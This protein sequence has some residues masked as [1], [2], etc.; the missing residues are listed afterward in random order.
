MILHPVAAWTPTDLSGP[1]RVRVARELG[2]AALRS[3]AL[4]AGYSEDA[5]P[6]RFPRDTAGAP[7]PLDPLRDPLGGEGEPWHWS[8]TGS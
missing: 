1:E 5:L 4:R 6:A 7:A 3:S 2:E 8:T